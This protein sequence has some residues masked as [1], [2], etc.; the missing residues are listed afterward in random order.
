M[1]KEFKDILLQLMQE[2]G[3][4]Q[5]KLAELLDIRQSQI[6]NLL[7]GKSAPQ[8]HT[9]RQICVHLQVS[10]DFLLGISEEEY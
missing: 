4:N 5:S 9:I 7:N 10:A 2:R 3:L 1:P 6:S 8:F